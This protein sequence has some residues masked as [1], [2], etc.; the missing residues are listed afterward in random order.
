[1]EVL[2]AARS[3]QEQRYA[4]GALAGLGLR[5]GDRVAFLLPGSTGLL[6]AVLGALRTGIVPVMLDPSLTPSERAQVL[7][8]AAPSLVVD[9]PDA[10]AALLSGEPAELAGVPLA[11]PMHYTSGTTG[12]R[13]GVWSG[14]LEEADAS[15]L[16]AEER[17]LWGF[18]ADDRHLVVSALYHSA[19]LRFAAGTLLAGGEV[20]VLP[21]FTPEGALAGLAQLRPTSLFCAPAHLQRLFEAVDAGATLPDLSAVRLLAHAGAPCP[22][23]L[24]QRTLEAFPDG[25]VWEFYGSTEGQ[26]TACSAADWAGHPGSVGPA[27]PG[28][29]LSVDPDGTIWCRVPPYARFTYWRDPDKTARAWRGDAFT[30]G[31]LGRLDEDGF[32]YLDGRREDLLLSGGVNVYPMEVEVVLSDCPGVVDLAVFGRPDERWGQRVCA[33]Y[34]GSASADEL[35]DWAAERLSPAKR[36]KEYHQ[37]QVLPRSTT[38]KVRRMALAADLGLDDGGTGGRG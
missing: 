34:A 38:G 18:R 22:A 20:A 5:T 8:D 35:R 16:L 11:R 31:D 13:K 25:S 7:D 33:V 26:F 30:V 28:R 27:R 24:K 19:P 1:V 17:D 29:E 10:L 3:E 14:V 6:S 9:A 23:P 21:R 12:R 36:P 37:V 2:T 4:A 15:A 32:V